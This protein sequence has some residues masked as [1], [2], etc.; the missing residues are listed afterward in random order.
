MMDS[1]P[2]LNEPKRKTNVRQKYREEMYLIFDMPEI[3]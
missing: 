2:K 1:F 3:T